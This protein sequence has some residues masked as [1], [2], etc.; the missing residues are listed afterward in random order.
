MTGC[1]RTWQKNYREMTVMK[2]CGSRRKGVRGTYYN[3]PG[4]FWSI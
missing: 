4:G 3:D 1:V 2:D